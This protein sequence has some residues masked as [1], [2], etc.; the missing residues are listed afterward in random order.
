MN[1]YFTQLADPRYRQA[2]QQQNLFSNLLN[3]GAQMSA[4]GAPSFDPGYAGRTRF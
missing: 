4:A 3:F 1:A 2:M